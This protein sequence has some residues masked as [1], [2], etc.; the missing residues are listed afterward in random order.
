MRKLSTVPYRYWSSTCRAV[1]PPL[2][3]VASL[4][5]LAEL[6]IENRYRV[7]LTV[8]GTGTREQIF[9]PRCYSVLLVPGYLKDLPGRHEIVGP[10]DDAAPAV[11]GTGVPVSYR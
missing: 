11:P 6:P 10:D 3:P 8:P 5:A 4:A 9:F 2:S 1:D 7:I